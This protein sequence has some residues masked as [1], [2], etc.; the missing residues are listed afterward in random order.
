MKKTILRLALCCLATC[1]SIPVFGDGVYQIYPIPHQQ[2]A[3]GG[4]TKI[5]TGKIQ[6]V[7]GDNIDSYTKNRLKNIL[8]ERHLI[9]EDED[10]F[11]QTPSEGYTHIFVGVNNSGDKAD[12]KATSSN[13]SRDVFMLQNKYDKHLLSI[14]DVNGNAEIIILGENTDASF[15]GMASLEQILDNNAPGSI[16]CGI[17]YDY[18][19][20]KNRGLVEG[21]YG[22]PY[23]IDVKKDIMKFMMRYKM[24]SYMYGA[25]SDYY[26]S[27]YWKQPYPV[28]ITEQQKNIGYLSQDMVKDLTQV[29]HETKVNF[30]W[31]IH[32]GNDFLNSSTVISD[33]MNKYKRMYAL[34]VRQFAVFVDDVA[35][36]STQAQY[37]LNAARV[38]SLQQAIEKE[39]NKNGASPAD[40]VKP[41][42]FVPQIY[43]GS[44]AGGGEAQRKA[45]FTALSKTPSNVVIYTTG[46]GVWSVPNSS[47]VQ[48]VRQYLGRDVAWWWNYPCNDNDA[49]KLFTMDMYTNFHD[50]SRISNTAT[51][52]KNLKNCLAV[53]SNPMQQG[54]VS[55]I[56]LFGVADYAWN[57]AAF[58]NKNNWNAAFSAIIND[59]ETAQAYQ[60]LAAHLRYY[61][62][63]ALSALVNA[64]KTA[65]NKQG[66]ADGTALKTSMQNIISAAQK[67]EQL[68]NSNNESDRLLFNDLSP[69]LKKLHSMAEQ[70]LALIQTAEAETEP[71]KWNT[72]E[73]T[74]TPI[75][76]L[77]TKAAH[78][79]PQLA[80]SVGA[81]LSLSTRRTNPSQETL[82]PFVQYLQEKSLG[83]LLGTPLSTN[84]I[85]FSNLE[86]VRGA[87]SKSKNTITFVNSCINTL[88][89]G[90]YVGLQL[91]QPV[92]LHS[93]T[94]A[95]TLFD[96]FT[97]LHSEN[98]KDWSTLE[99][100]QQ[101]NSH[102]RY[103]VIENETEE[104]KS[105]KLARAVFKADLPQPTSIASATLPSGDIYSGHN[106]SFMTD[107]DYTT[108]TCLNRNQKNNDA[109]VVTLDA[110]VP[111]GDVRICMGTVN[112]DYMTVGRVQISADG[113]N[114]KTLCV[115]GTAQT[116]FRMTLPQVVKH[117]DEMSYCD[118][119]GKN[120]TA[121][122]VRLLVTTANTSKWLRLY[123]IEVNKATYAAK[124]KHPAV[125]ASGNALLSLTD[126]AGN[127][128]LA[129]AT[130]SGN[131]LFYHFY[132]AH[133]VKDVVIFQGAASSAQNVAVSAL[134]S[135]GEWH[136]LGHLTGGYQILSL[137]EANAPSC[138]RITWEGKTAPAIYEIREDLSQNDSPVVS[139]IET[140][141]A[142]S[143]APVSVSIADGRRLSIASAEGIS[144]CSIFT[145]DGKLLL[146][147][148]PHGAKSVQLPAVA[149]PAHKVLILKIETAKGNIVNCK[150]HLK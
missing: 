19:D 36:P 127:T 85:I 22:V 7:C 29:S 136:S 27:A 95:D 97:L 114:W 23:S 39:W 99:K 129:D 80:G 72:Y 112:G 84:P 143:A 150:L 70:V 133:A 135:S 57:N 12:A 44:F 40:T 125:D 115:K 83:N 107:G 46:W 106:A 124:F 132:D 109:Y 60:L 20:Q 74:I 41:L 67:I 108:Y 50:E 117:S 90:Q 17:I 96:S 25:K 77:D 88:N 68:E 78:Q 101:P 3:L 110:P 141:S 52:D 61:D 30:I 92:M 66:K 6:V 55:K 145:I 21:Y 71:E 103:I 140:T 116:D 43:C 1:C 13:L 148:R 5:L 31:A 79:A 11:V 9:S 104:P 120:D 16:P 137:A 121:K 47:D 58:N 100:G 138:I 18:A 91:P 10:I 76:Q 65:F 38:T 4:T 118:F 64:Y 147:Q 8:S 149:A 113:K 56:A 45:F 34:G 26:H 37:D 123:D 49:D 122:Y 59:K 14:Q 33:I 28:S 119:N 94:V 144:A 2:Q 81:Q 69:W 73:Q 111:V 82:R 146:A 24:N 42:Q 134:T 130:P 131:A 51:V 15:I 32:P 89:K 142:A 54:E 86:K 48:S 139:S 63:N 126:K 128:A 62:S 102:V 75:S 105:L 53:L 98:G 87:V 35:I 93:I